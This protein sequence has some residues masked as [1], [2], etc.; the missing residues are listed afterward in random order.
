MTKKL[1]FIVLTGWQCQECRLVKSQCQKEKYPAAFG[2]QATQQ[3]I[4]HI[5]GAD[6]VQ[7]AAALLKEAE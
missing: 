7:G 1:G 2:V 4:S 6:G 5:P 3:R